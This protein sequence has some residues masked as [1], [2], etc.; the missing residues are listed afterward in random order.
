VLDEALEAAVKLSHRY[1]PARQLPTKRSAPRHVVRASRSASTASCRGRH[2]RRRI[3]RSTPSS[4]SSPARQVGIDTK[5]HEADAQDK[6]AAEVTR[7]AGLETRW[8]SEKGL[9]DRIL[10]LRAK[11]RGA[12]QP[13]EGTKSKLEKE[14]A[15]AA[16]PATSPADREA[17]LRE[18]KTLQGELDTLQGDTPLIL[19]TVGEQAVGSVVQDWTGIP[20]GRMVKNE[21]ET[22]LKLSDTINQRV[23]GQKHGLDMIARRIQT[24]R[25]ALD[26]EQADRRLS[27]LRALASARPK[28]PLTDSPRPCTVASRTSSRSAS[29]YRRRT[30]LHPRDRLPATS[31]T[32][33]AASHRGRTT[34]AVQRRP[35]RRGRE[36]AP[37]RPRD[38]PSR[39]STRADGG[40]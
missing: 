28:P 14:A 3:E 24:S 36:S 17:L 39:S 29:E 21:I 31:A 15:A 18:L 22:V 34:Q 5:S 13:V 4:R 1:I 37:G 40:R 19:P 23:V 30:P 26:N 38:L 12:A 16:P 25:A 20:V 27:A 32:A 35:S 8:K 7:L 10:E 9:V 6:R 11:L 2:S 33:R